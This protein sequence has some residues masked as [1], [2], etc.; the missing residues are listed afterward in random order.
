[1]S[2]AEKPRLFFIDNVRILLVILVVSFHAGAPYAGVPWFMIPAE[3][4]ALSEVVLG[5]FLTVCAA[6]FLG[7]FFMISGYFS[8]GS[9]DRKGATLFLKDRFVRLGI[10]LIVFYTAVMPLFRYGMYFLDADDPLSLWEFLAS[11]YHWEPYHLWF[12]EALLVFTVL[13]CVWRGL[14]KETPQKQLRTPQNK[15]IFV[16]AVFLTVVTFV[17]RI[18]VPVGVWDPLKVVPPAYLPQFLGLFSA[19]IISYRQNWV[20]KVS[21]SVGMM[22]LRI[23][24]ITVLLFPVIYRMSGGEYSSLTGGF[25][26]RPF[27]FAVWEAF[28]CIGLCV[29]VLIYFREKVN[30][31]GRLQRA[32]SANVY[33]V[34]LIH[35][36]VVIFVQYTLIGVMLHPFM[37]FLVVTMAGILF[38]FL[39]SHFIRTLPFA[40]KIL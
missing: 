37:K 28:V 13:Y 25:H 27:I 23:G 8:P 5:W 22:W 9:C 16:A 14:T 24:L 3:T 20:M 10:P 39:I 29:G 15:D 31:Q 1:M 36:P 40:E 11:A 35:F 12:I 18:W 2:S 26:W 32:L 38:S 33:A 19:G 17:V 4:T 7:F 30:L 21:A 34:Y 6:F